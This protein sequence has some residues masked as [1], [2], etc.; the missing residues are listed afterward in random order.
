M[1][2]RCPGDGSVHWWNVAYIYN[3]STTTPAA[4]VGTVLGPQSIAVTMCAAA[5][6]QGCTPS[7]VHANTQRPRCRDGFLHVCGYLQYSYLSKRA[8]ATLTADKAVAATVQSCP[9]LPPTPLLPTLK[10][11]DDRASALR[12]ITGAMLIH[13]FAVRSKDLAG[14][15]GKEM[16]LEYMYDTIRPVIARVTT[17]VTQH[18]LAA[19]LLDRYMPKRP[20]AATQEVGEMSGSQKTELGSTQELDEYTEDTTIRLAFDANSTEDYPKN[21]ATRYKCGIYVGSR[22][23]VAMADCTSPYV[24]DDAT[25]ANS[26]L[27][28]QGLTR[29][30]RSGGGSG[31]AVLR[32]GTYSFHV[33]PTDHAGNAGNVKT[34]TWTVDTGRPSVVFADQTPDAWF[35]TPSVP[36][37]VLCTE[38]GC[39]FE[40]QLEFLEAP[41]TD[42]TSIGPLPRKVLEPYTTCG[43]GH[44]KLRIL[45][46][47]EAAGLARQMQFA[48][49]AEAGLATDLAARF[50]T[51]SVTGAKVSTATSGPTPLAQVQ[52]ELTL[53]TGQKEDAALLQTAF[54]S[55]KGGFAEGKRLKVSKANS[56]CCPL[57]PPPYY[58]FHRGKIHTWG[59]TWMFTVG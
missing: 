49:S 32:D 47:P 12:C 46:Q 13:R 33:A 28:R 30:G 52:F 34:F 43:L 50:P 44:I 58:P 22:S 51:Y 55:F 5:I 20:F 39:T 42:F 38:P 27:A 16:V 23:V 36:F 18:P 14:N 21:G 59:N 10:E 57:R 54:E 25:L 19:L 2:S 8:L 7:H 31:G 26:S 9:V 41:T 53:K 45:I 11:V 15:V 37:G 17:S 3:T 24:I 35:P 48:D 29:D 1:G 40:C 56:K 4:S 6:R